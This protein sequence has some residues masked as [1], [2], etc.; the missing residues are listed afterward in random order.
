MKNPDRLFTITAAALSGLYIVVRFWGLTDSC[1]WFDEIFGVH[2]AELPTDDMLWFVAQDL[3]H[4]PLFYLLL[5]AWI[6]FGGESLFWLRGFSVF[7]SIAALAP[8]LLLCKEIKLRFSARLVALAFFAVNGAL[9]KYAQEVRMYGLLLFLSL[10]STWLFARYFYRGKSIWTLTFVNVL[11][12]YTHYFGWFVVASEITVILMMQRIKIRHMLVMFS[13]LVTSYAPWV[14][15]IIQAG[16]G[17]NVQQNIGWIE[18]PGLRALLDLGFDVIEP[19]YFQQSNGEPTTIL[20]VTFPLL[21]AVAIAKVSY[22][23]TWRK[24]AVGTTIFVLAVLSLLPLVLAFIVSWVFP[25][26]IWGTRHLIVVFPV[27]MIVIGVLIDSV[28]PKVGKVALIAFVSLLFCTALAFRVNA[29]KPDFIWCAWEQ[30]AA[31]LS[32]DVPRTVYVFEDLVAYHMWFAVRKEPNIHIVKV[33]GVPEMKE[34]KA[35]FL[36]RGF[37]SVSRRDLSQISE[38]EVTLVFRA[39]EL[40]LSE[41]PLK[42]FAYSGYSISTAGEYDADGQKSFVVKLDKAN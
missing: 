42:N 20:F 18:K 31:A 33:D 41:P 40:K 8:F 37:D 25:F 30:Q 1:L 35:Y 36:P 34:D 32:G 29:P 14:W 2:A 38:R 26:S 12:V 6:S 15:A 10:V 7:W 9:I 19:F 24:R 13:I 16:S 17:P 22:F 23:V 28:E 27:M 21:V 5:K 4:P 11:L 39:T 3:I